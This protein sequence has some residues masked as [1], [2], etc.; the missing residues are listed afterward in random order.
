[1]SLSLSKEQR[2]EV[3]ASIRRLFSEKLELELS[4]LQAGF[5]LEYF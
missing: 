4:E 1:M 3:I 2:A 5:V